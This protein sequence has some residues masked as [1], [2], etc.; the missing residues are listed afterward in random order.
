MEAL[1]TYYTAWIKAGRPEAGVTVDL[2]PM[3]PI[4]AGEHVCPPGAPNMITS[5]VT[6]SYIIECSSKVE[7][8]AIQASGCTA[9]VVK[10]PSCHLACEPSQLLQKKG[11]RLLYHLTVSF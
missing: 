2:G 10:V 4:A 5:T 9:E 6:R 7:A 1:L 3:M 8:E 11:K